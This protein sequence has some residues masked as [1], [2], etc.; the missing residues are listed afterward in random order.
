MK[1]LTEI[2]KLVF[3]TQQIYHQWAD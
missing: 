2:T 1:Q 3:I